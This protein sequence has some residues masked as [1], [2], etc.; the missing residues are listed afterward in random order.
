M[1]SYNCSREETLYDTT[2]KTIRLM[3]SVIP[4][5][6]SKKKEKKE[7]KDVLMMDDPANLAKVYQLIQQDL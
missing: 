7:D 3:N 6:S 5:Y 2:Y 4:S 1:K